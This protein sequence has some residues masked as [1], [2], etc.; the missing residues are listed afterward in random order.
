MSPNRKPYGDNKEWYDVAQICTTGHVV[1]PEVETV[2]AESRRFCEQC[3]KP[4]ITNC[5]KCG[6]DILG[7]GQHTGVRIVGRDLSDYRRPAY[8]NDCGKPYPWTVSELRAAR[9]F[10][11]RLEQLDPKER[12]DL[13]RDLGQV[14][15]RTPDS[16]N[17]LVRARRLLVEAGVKASKE[18]PGLIKEI[19][20]SVAADLIRHPPV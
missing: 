8:C 10:A 3:G 4:T 13:K 11:D 9:T 2:P 12:K 7:F 5:P 15:N 6:A 14:A 1:T 20:V 18:T 16:P 17:A 19:L